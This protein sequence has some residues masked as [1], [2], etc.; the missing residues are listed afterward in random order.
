[1]LQKLK[2]YN[3]YLLII[4]TCSSI[5]LFSPMI[6]G[7]EE[8]IILALGWITVRVPIVMSPWRSHS[9]QTIAPLA[10]FTLGIDKENIN[11]NF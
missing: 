3:P 7:P 4:W 8:A 2:K 5:M 1:M 11:T 6:M 10:I 9:E